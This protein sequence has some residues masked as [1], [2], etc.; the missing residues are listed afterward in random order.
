MR[1]DDTK[2]PFFFPLFQQ[3]L[4]NS[5]T[6]RRLCPRAKFI[7]QHQRPVVGMQKDFPHTQQ[8]RTVRAQIVV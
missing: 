5:P 7:Y 3:R 1:G 8:M 6:G 2:T 4:G